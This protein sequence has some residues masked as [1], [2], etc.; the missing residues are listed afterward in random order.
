MH[1]IRYAAKAAMLAT[2]AFAL[3]S[4]ATPA[5][6]RD[7]GEQTYVLPAQPLAASLRAVSEISGIGI[8][9][10]G[11]LL[12]GRSAPVLEGDYTVEAAIA[13]LLAGSGLRAHRVGEGLVIER[14]A[15]GPLPAQADASES[16]RIVVTGS[17]IRGAPVASQ[18]IEIDAEEIRRGGH[19]DLGQVVRSIPQS[20]GGGQNPGVGTN[21]PASSGVDVGGGSSLNLRG[22]GSDATLTLLNGHRLNYSASRQSVDISAIPLAA[23]ER[24]EVVADGA[25]AL[26]GSDAVGGVANII[27]R[28]DADGIE[29][30]ARLGSS[31]DGGY[32]QQAYGALGGAGWSSGGFVAAY[33][34]GSNSSIEAQDRSYSATRSP[35]VTL[36]PQIRRH[37]AIFNAHQDFSGGASLALDALYNRRTSERHFPLNPAGD[38]D[39]SGGRISSS[40]ESFAINPALR[41]SLPGDWQLAASAGYGRERVDFAA[42]LFFSGSPVPGG[43]GYYVNATK[44]VELAGDGSLLDLPAGPVRLAA[45]AGYRSIDFAV[46]KGEGSFENQS[47]SQDNYFAYGELSLPL[48]ASSAQGATTPLL[49]FSAALRYENYPG[50]G[51]VATPKIGVVATPTA[52]FALKASW[53]RSFRAP[54]LLQQYNPL[55][56]SLLPTSSVGGAGYPADATVLLAQGGNPDLKP[57]RAESW[58]ATLDLHPRAVPGMRLELSYFSLRYRDRIVTPIGATAVALSN[59]VYADLVTLDPSDEAKA[60]ILANAGTFVNLVEGPY[61]PSKVAAIVDNRNVNAGYQKLN[62]IDVLLRYRRELPGRAGSLDFVLSGAWLDSEQQLSAGQAVVPLAGTLFNPPNLRARGMLSWSVGALTAAGTVNYSGA[63][64]DK[65]FSPAARIGSVT[66]LDLTVRLGTGTRDDWTSDLELGL[67]VL[68][69]LNAKPTPIRTTLYTDTAYDSTNY[70]PIGRFFAVELRQTW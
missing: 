43:A 37:S 29:T 69:A 23:V 21:V 9:A 53:G 44:S 48:I 20:F 55:S 31:T 49:N 8:V 60:A 50:I 13:A 35:G 19:A 6:A 11:E 17:R 40:A 61:E 45:G 5:C 38:L 25:S 51:D 7:N 70:S 30:S 33:E 39:L 26:Y 67:T 68:N 15:A 42:D 32:F 41:L 63:V 36:F 10:P 22:I 59:P 56:V 12:E 14:D 57:E 62:G 18:V 66:T 65:R 64:A 24:I 27:L 3:L 52:D 28:R 2:T 4:I 46:F 47:R 34:H 1:S 16:D 58:S 54:T